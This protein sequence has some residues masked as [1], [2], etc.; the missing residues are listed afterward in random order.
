MLL[1]QLFWSVTWLPRYDTEDYP[2]IRDRMFDIFSHGVARPGTAWEPKPLAALYSDLGD[3]HETS[4]E[5]FLRVAT[6]LINFRGYRGASVEKI[7]AQLNVTKGSFYHH[8]EAKDDLVVACFERSFG[9]MRRA[10]SLAMRGDGDLWSKLSSAA[11][12]LAEYQL[13]EAGPLL[14]SSA[15]SALPEPIRQGMVDQF[16]RASDRFAA[17][18]SDGIAEGSLRAVDPS[19]AA[20][21]L[22]ATLN[23]A[24]DLPFVIPGLQGAEMGKLYAKPMLMSIFER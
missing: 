5:T 19:I 3:T 2:R 17:M 4:R 14:R 20:Q 22:N 12:A 10:Q 8:N 13:S 23:G 11:A 15:L 9:I 18:I 7:S 6:K 24:A 16:S 1:E 21:M